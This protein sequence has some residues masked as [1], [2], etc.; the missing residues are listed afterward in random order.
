MNVAAY[1]FPNY[2]RGDARNEKLHG[3][4]WNEW[5]LVKRA[6]PRF[7]GHEQPKVPLW[8]YDDEADPMCMAKRI[9]AAADHGIN[10]FIFDWYWYNDGAFLE[11]ALDEG[12]LNAPN[13][14]RIQFALMWANHD[15]IDIHPAKLDEINVEHS[16]KLLYPGAVT[17]E[18][19]E[20]IMDHCIETYFKHPSYWLIDGCPYFSIYE[21]SKLMAGFG[22]ECKTRKLLDRFRE[23]VRAAGFP[24]L[25]L[26]AIVWNN[27]VLPGEQTPTDCNELVKLLGFDSVNSYVWIH[28]AKLPDFPT[29][30]YSVMEE[31]YFQYWDKAQKECPV[32]YYPNLSMGWDPSPRTV[33]SDRYLLRGYPFTPIVTGNTP[34]AFKAAA[35]KIFDRMQELDL[36]NPFVSINAW[37]EWTEGSY[38][39]P[40]EKNGYAY[41]EAI[42]DVFAVKPDKQQLIPA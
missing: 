40:D 12:F 25:H 41:L 11:K 1:Y 30:E 5:D 10:T 29:N 9:D 39:E 31:Q 37:N 23:K 18:T 17:A 26:N 36:P 15:W 20:R 14:D 4:G 21:L 7:P 35:Q 42:R 24:D 2:H 22:C 13:N 32:P 38:L 28:H 8:G 33:Q 19:F 16:A 27:P 3:P 6:E 34:E